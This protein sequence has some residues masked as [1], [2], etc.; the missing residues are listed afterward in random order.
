MQHVL[1]VAEFTSRSGPE[2]PVT[3]PNSAAV[4]KNSS[5]LSVLIVDDEPLI[6]WSLRRGLT[7]RGHTVV[8]ATTAAEAL[9]AIQAGVD[10]F[11]VVILDYRLPDRRDLSLLQDVRGIAPNAAVLMMTAYGE[12]DMRSRA[13]SLGAVAVVDKPFQVNE[14]ISLIESARAE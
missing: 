3:A 5:G 4:A 8:E 14:L 12:T 2:N 7:K 6:R 1:S 11:A 9:E 10:R 13:L